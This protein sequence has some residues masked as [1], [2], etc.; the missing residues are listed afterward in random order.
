[1]ADPLGRPESDVR[2]DHFSDPTTKYAA[3]ITIKPVATSAR[4]NHLNIGEATRCALQGRIGR[5]DLN[6]A[7]ARQRNV[8]G[9]GR[10][11]AVG[12]P[13]YLR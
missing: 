1:M 13:V 12:K 6:P 3:T 4:S 2:P 10:G 8:E 9:V 5:E 11:Q 7:S